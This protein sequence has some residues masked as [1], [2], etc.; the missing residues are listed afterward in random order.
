MPVPFGDIV[1]SPFVFVV[2]MSLPSTVILSTAKEVTPAISVVVAPSVNVDEPKVIVGFAKLAFE[3]AALPDKLA[4]VNVVAVT[5]TVLSV[6]V[7]TK[8]EPPANV[9][10]SAVL[11]V[12]VPVS[13]AKLIN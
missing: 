9:K 4:F 2:D 8:P 5:V 1:K 11:Y 13:P 6:T 12:S 3:I 10:V 7:C